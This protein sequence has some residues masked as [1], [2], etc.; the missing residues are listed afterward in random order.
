[1][2]RDGLAAVGALLCACAVALAAYASHA[3]VAGQGE[4]LGLAAAFAFAHG[5]ALLLPVGAS[6]AARLARL[7]W[8]LGVAGFCGGLVFAALT[9]GRAVTAPV[10]GGLLIL[11]WLLLAL[12]RLRA[13]PE[14]NS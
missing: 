11:G 8:L 2:A 12:D 7:C 5:L 10:G 4:R 9:E 6:L 3:E 13:S 1:M 14:S